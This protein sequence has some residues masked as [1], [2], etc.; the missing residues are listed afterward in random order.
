M[1]RSGIDTVCN[2]KTVEE[3]QASKRSPVIDTDRSGQMP[4]NESRNDCCCTEEEEER[5]DNDDLCA[6]QGQAAAGDGNGRA[7][8]GH[9]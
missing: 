7:G 9:E 2:Q 4:R 1:A 3:D 8:R 5:G 6:A